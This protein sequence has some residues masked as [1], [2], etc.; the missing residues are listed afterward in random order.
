MPVDDLESPEELMEETVLVRVMC[1][2]D[3]DAIVKIDADASGRSRP[4]YFQLM[5]DRTV[6]QTGVQISLVAEMDDRVVGFAIG[7]LFY[8]EYGILEPTASIDAIS[9]ARDARRQRVGDAL[10]RQ[11]RTNLSALGVTTLRT[12]VSWS[13]FDLLAFFKREGFAPAARLCLEQRLSD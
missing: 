12:E 2:S 11:L 9:V 4:K 3:L 1:E 13:D 10:M 8:G 5:F 7:S 6:R